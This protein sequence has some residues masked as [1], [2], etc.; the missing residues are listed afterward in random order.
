[1]KQRPPLT[2][3]GRTAIILNKIQHDWRPPSWKSLWRHNSAADDPISMKFYKP[4]EN[5]MP[6]TVKRSKSKLK[7]EFESGGRLFIETGSSNISAVDWGV[8]S[9]IGTPRALDLL[10]CEAWPNQKP[11]IDLRRYDR[12]LVKWIWRHTS[13]GDHPISIKSGRPK[14]MQNHMPMTAKRSPLK[15]EV[16]FQYSGSLFSGN[17]E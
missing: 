7:V 4:M 16:K 13:V 6:M 10:K 15:P 5:H 17:R 8:W 9:K 12:H 14:P 3:R 1:M 2:L 11:E